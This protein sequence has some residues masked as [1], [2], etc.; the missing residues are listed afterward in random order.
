MGVKPIPPSYEDGVH[1][2]HH[3]PKFWRK[4]CNPFKHFGKYSM[5]ESNFR[6][7]GVNEMR[8]HFT[9]RAYTGAAGFEPARMTLEI[10]MLP[11]HHAPSF[12]LLLFRFLQEVF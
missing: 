8:Y 10:I 4:R 2:L 7:L 3:F 12:N 9:N 1:Q 11:L 5:K 6:L